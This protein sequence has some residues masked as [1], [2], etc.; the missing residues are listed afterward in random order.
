MRPFVALI[1]W[2]GWGIAVSGPPT[3]LSAQE[4]SATEVVRRA[5]EQM[6]GKSSLATF[7]ITINRPSWSREMK[8]K[9]WA[10]GERFSMILITAPA[11]EKGISFLK[12]EREVWNWIPAIER[13]IKLPPSMM[14]QSWMG[15]DFTNDDLVKEASAVSDYQHRHLGRET[16]GGRE[17][18]QIEMIPKPEAAIVW[19]KVIVWID[20][21]DFLQLKTE[22]YDEDGELVNVMYGSEPKVLGGRLI[23]SKIEMVPTDKEGHSTVI[24]Y[25]DI[26]FDQEIPDDFF[27]P[28]NM[29]R[30]Q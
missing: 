10:K 18:Y 6:R 30:L 29:T 22:F 24:Q 9:A 8:L 23:T 12:R 28:R 4:L 7:S 26:L 20:T 2:V 19:E 27:T 16:I 14:S 11:R 17:C 15:T 3:C 5:D 21:A 25:E 13:N 1:L